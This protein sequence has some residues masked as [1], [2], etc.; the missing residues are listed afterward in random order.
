MKFNSLY[1]LIMEKEEGSGLIPEDELKNYIYLHFFDDIE[2]A[3]LCYKYLKFS[4]YDKKGCFIAYLP[5]KSERV[6]PITKK[7]V[8]EDIFYI[9]LV[10]VLYNPKERKEFKLRFAKFLKSKN[11]PQWN[12]YLAF[13]FNLGKALSGLGGVLKYD[14]LDEYNVDSETKETWRGVLDTL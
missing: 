7:N 11:F 14:P 13:A 9:V 4:G 12:L 2:E 6:L 8:S 10:P 5:E 3:K 1:S